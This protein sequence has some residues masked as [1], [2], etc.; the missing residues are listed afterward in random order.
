MPLA[1][2]SMDNTGI[3]AT[4][5]YVDGSLL[6]VLQRSCSYDRPRPCSDEPVGDVGLPTEEL[7]DGVHQV[8][9][10]AVD[11]AGN[12][13]KI[14][15]PEQIKIDNNAPQ[16]PVGAISPAPVSAS[17]R[18]AVHWSLPSDTGSPIVAARYQVCQ[19]GTCGA[20]IGAPSLSGV[21]D[22]SLPAA[23]DGV[24]KVWLVD[25]VGHE[26]PA[27]AAQVALRYVPEPAADSPTPGAPAPEGQAPTPVPSPGPTPPGDPGGPGAVPGPNPSKPSTPTR[28]DAALKLS[29]VR[30]AG[31]RVLVRGTISKRA[32]GRLTVRFTGTPRHGRRVVVTARPAIR[33]RRFSAT[34]TIPR[35]AASLRRGSVSVTYAGDTD[36]RSSSRRA[37]VRWRS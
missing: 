21:D 1:M 7:V 17:N 11:A 19:A 14:E 22:V 9:L 28:H 8:S 16:A 37:T 30:V 32:S 6:K 5:V 12:E 13:T 15:R 4:K 20:V 33:A 3:A 27:S 18:F 24:V 34:L 2:A 10:G 31:R 23:G 29:S 35:K 26:Q 25:E 36:T